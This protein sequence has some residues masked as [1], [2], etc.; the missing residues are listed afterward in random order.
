[1]ATYDTTLKQLFRSNAAATLRALTG[2][3][4]VRWLDVELPRVQNPRIDLLGET[5]N[6][7]L[8]HIELQSY[9]APEMPLRMCEYCLAIYRKFARFPR[10]ILLYVGQ[11]AMAMPPELRGPDQLVRWTV[12]DIRE[13]DAE[14]LLESPEVSDNVIGVLARLR[15]RRRAVR[16]ILERCAE[17]PKG[18]R[19][20]ALEQ[21]ALLSG[22]RRMVTLVKEEAHDMPVIIDLNENE[23]LGPAYRKGLREGELA[24]L[25]RQI[26]KRFAEVPEWTEERLA[27]MSPAELEVL[28]ERLLQAGS[29]EDLFQ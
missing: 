3:E 27:V 18:R 19:D 15:D 23:I 14:P 26:L 12:L 16:R 10:Q 13:L 21:L 4:I 17:L 20:E 5:A 9:N 25:R 22:L 11:A 29:L 28:G 2:T 6:G 7:E 24:M 8:I 1:M